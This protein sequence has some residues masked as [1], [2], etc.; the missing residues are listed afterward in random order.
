MPTALITGV[1]GQD[2]SLL[3]EL[4]LD[5]GYRVVGVARPGAQ[6]ARELHSLVSRITMIE[7]DLAT[8]GWATELVRREQPDEVYHLAAC[9][10]SSEPGLRDD[11]ETQQRMVAVNHAAALALAHALLVVDR[12]RLVVAG[13]S[14]MYTPALPPPRITEAIP[15]APATFYGVTKASTLDALAWLRTHQGLGASTAILFNHES[16]RRPPAFV[17]RKIT[18]AAARIAAGRAHELVLGDLSSR[19]DFCSAVDV[20][21][22]LAAM[23]THE[24][25]DRVLASGELHGLADLCAAAFGA[26][27]LDWRAYVR[28]SQPA[29]DRPA[30]VGDPTRAEHELGWRRRRDFTT[31]VTEMVSADRDR[32]ARED[33]SHAV[34]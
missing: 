17:S 5:R 10:R 27:G 29:G 22:A 31:W 9:H 32:V 26:V 2:G 6:V 4:L 30:L 13:S 24:P 7:L 8:T 20:V 15:R 34:S 19:A 11:P 23:A 18:L 3:A 16:P 12:G 14:Q 1:L 28:S 21:E 33:V 25:A